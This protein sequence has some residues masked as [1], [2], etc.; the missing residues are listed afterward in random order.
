MRPLNQA[1]TA[2][3]RVAGGDLAVP[4]EARGND[5]TGPLL[6]AVQCMQVSLTSTVS[7]V[8]SNADGVVSAST[9]IAQGNNDLSARTEQQ[10]SALEETAASMEELSSTVTQNADNARQANQL[11]TS[12]SG[13]WSTPTVGVRV[14][15][16][17][18]RNARLSAGI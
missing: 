14:D 16:T 3:G 17:G 7:T 1:V 10:A 6:K 8:R 12:A 15:S 18:R 4:I 13:L 2:I 5:E 9:Q 11:A